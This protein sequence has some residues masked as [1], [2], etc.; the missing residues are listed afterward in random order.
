MARR[1][2]PLR[3]R[4]R[5]VSGPDNSTV[6]SGLAGEEEEEGEDFGEE[7]FEEDDEG[8]DDEGEFVLEKET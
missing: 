3:A 2:S 7:G 8:E 4:R 1:S 5:G 6:I